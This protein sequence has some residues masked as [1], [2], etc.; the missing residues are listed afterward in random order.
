M[1]LSVC[2]SAGV[3]EYIWGN[4]CC[5][6]VYCMCSN[7]PVCL[8]KGVNVVLSVCECVWVWDW[9]CKSVC[10]QTWLCCVPVIVWRCKYVFTSLHTRGSTWACVCTW[11]WRP[12]AD[13]RILYLL[14]ST[15]LGWDAA[16][17]SLILEFT[18][19][20]NPAMQLPY[21][22]CSLCP[23]TG[24][25][26][27]IAFP[28]LPHL[29]FYT[30]ENSA[31]VSAVIQGRDSR[32]IFFLSFP[33]QN[34]ISQQASLSHRQNAHVLSRQLLF[35]R[36]HLIPWCHTADLPSFHGWL[37][38]ICSPCR[39][40]ENLYKV[41]ATAVLC[42]NVSVAFSFQK[43]KCLID[44]IIERAT[45]FKA[46]R[47]WSLNKIIYFLSL[48]S[49]PGVL[50]SF[51][52]LWWNTLTTSSLGGGFPWLI[53]PSYGSLLWRSQGRDSSS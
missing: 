23:V 12:T 33:L 47:Y 42:L 34:L 27:S 49:P 29:V 2:A 40:Q 30:S 24:D 6:R 52:S 46:S 26:C 8:Y 50:F 5:V 37:P 7:V 14:W 31:T 10:A 18:D 48:N 35:Y 43:D 16:G 51:L 19:M 41:Q 13:S 32:V 28:L 38:A 36:R 39:S 11:V 1:C 17:S 25:F 44:L 53:I 45:L 4:V 3:W 20:T 15:L 9:M 22:L 21:R